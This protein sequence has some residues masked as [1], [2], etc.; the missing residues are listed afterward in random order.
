MRARAPQ[1]PFTWPL[2]VQAAAYVV[3][4]ALACLPGS[5]A[6]SSSTFSVTAFAVAAIIVLFAFFCPL[7]DGVPGRVTAVVLGFVA[8]VCASTPLLGQFVF[9]RQGAPHAGTANA[10]YYSAAAWCA[11]VAG[12]LVVLVVAAFI[13]QMAR[14]QR[15]DMMGA[16]HAGTANAQYYSAAAWCAGVAGLLVVLVVAAFIRQMARPQRTDMIVQLAHMVTDGVASIAASGWCFLPMLFHEAGAADVWRIVCVV[17]VVA[18]AVALA[19]VSRL[20]YRSIAASG[21]CF[22]PMLFHEAGAADVWRIVCVVVVVAGAVAL[23]M[24]SRLWYRE[25]QPLPG[26]R[27][28]WIGFGL[29]PVMLTGAL[30]G[31]AALIMWLV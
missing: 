18:G 16:P 13:R 24:V 22:L 21:W 23:A 27:A 10:Q 31:I 26:A 19:M 5:G 28:A 3:L 7:R 25:A 1:R 14:P 30:V 9:E 2:S 20:W 15:T 29:L 11:G 4:I 17:V 12:L 8:M 6:V